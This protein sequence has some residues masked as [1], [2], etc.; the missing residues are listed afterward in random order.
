MPYALLIYRTKVGDFPH[1][2]TGMGNGNAESREKDL[3]CCRCMVQ[4]KNNI[5]YND[6]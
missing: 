3:H 6:Y 4:L 2:R 1:P 5:I